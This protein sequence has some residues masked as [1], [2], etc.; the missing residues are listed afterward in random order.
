MPMLRALAVAAAVLWLSL[1]PAAALDLFATHEVTVQFATADGK[2]MADADVKVF[3][4][5][6]QSRVVKTGK[7]DKDGKF[8]F[9]ADRDGFWTAEARINGDV[10]RASIRVG[11]ADEPRGGPSPF[12]VIGGLLVLLV[13]AVW[14]RFLRARS[15]GR[16]PP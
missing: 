9:G 15:R 16:G 7:T 5:A 13:I 3:A 12:L 4:P 6:D 1:S 2:P 11:G 10:A 8:T 14:Y